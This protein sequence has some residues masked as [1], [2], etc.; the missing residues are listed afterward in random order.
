M[1]SIAAWNI[2]G[3]NRSLKQNEVRNV[4]RE[5]KLQVCAIMESHMDVSRM[6][7]VCKKICR[8]WDWTSNG[9]MC[10]KGM[11]IIIGWNS[12]LVDLM[13]L[14]QSSQVIHVQL[15]FKVERKAM[16]CSFVYAK[17]H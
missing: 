17:N 4:V 5:N 1:G 7:D 16:F 11:R 8:N 15:F 2:R 3:L 10:D 6:F 14:S 9:A 13:V 12:D